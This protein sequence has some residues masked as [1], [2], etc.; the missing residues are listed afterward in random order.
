MKFLCFVCIKIV[1]HMK[2]H[3]IIRSLSKNQSS[4]QNWQRTH[5]N[6]N[7]DL[8]FTLRLLKYHSFYSQGMTKLFSIHAYEKMIFIILNVRKR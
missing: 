6:K 5:K 1:H 8:D 4:F 3:R 7:E 2:K